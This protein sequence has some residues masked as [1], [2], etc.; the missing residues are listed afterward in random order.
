MQLLLKSIL[1]NLFIMLQQ[2]RGFLK[3]GKPVNRIS[4][5]RDSPMRFEVSA[6]R[7]VMTILDNKLALSPYDVASTFESFDP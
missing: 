4:A 2:E 1:Q 5:Q 6:S 3:R 7:S